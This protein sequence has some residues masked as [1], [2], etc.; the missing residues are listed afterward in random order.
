MA[1]IKPIFNQVILKIA[2]RTDKWVAQSV[3]FPGYGMNTSNFGVG[4]PAQAQAFASSETSVTDLSSPS[5]KLNGHPFLFPADKANIA[6]ISPL[7][8]N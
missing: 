2:L 5:L 8:A 7:T 4:F 3:G 1:N 6:I